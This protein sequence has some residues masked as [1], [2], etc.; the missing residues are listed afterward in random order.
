VK[1]DHRNLELTYRKQWLALLENNGVRHPISL[2]VIAVPGIIVQMTKGEPAGSLQ[3]DGSPA[4]VLMV[5]LS[6]V[7]DLRQ[8]RAQRSFVS[9]MLHG[10][11]TLMP[12]GVRSQWSWN[13]R[14]DRLDLVI[15]PD[16]LG[17]E[18]NLE[19]VDRWR[20]RDNRLEDLSRELCRELSLR[21]NAD[22]VRIETLAIQ[23]AWLLQRDYATDSPRAERPS[24][25]GLTHEKARLIVEYV[26]ANLGRHMSIR[27]LAN[28]V[29][30]G[31]YHFVRMFK[32]SLALTPHRYV[33][34]RRIERAKELLQSSCAPLAEIGLSLGF[35]TQSHF[36]STFHRLVG[37]TP[38]EFRQIVG[39][40]DCFLHHV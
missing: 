27:E 20:F 6:P 25:G 39:S 32:R 37:N 5:N 31:P 1:P 11:M 28:L 17:D 8:V 29:Q 3:L 19:T 33:L 12:V 34:E 38:G 18:I 24:S 40:V 26:E 36:T 2:Q 7:Q 16:A 15:T 13:S 4:N 14:C 22:R 23:A 9:N 21:A 35:N 10:D 30:L